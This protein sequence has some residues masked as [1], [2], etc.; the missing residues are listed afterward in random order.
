MSIST[1][2]G[3]VGTYY[4]GLKGWE[5]SVEGYWKR[6]NNVLEYKDGKM[7][8]SSASNWEENV[9]MG[10]GRSY[11]MEVYVQKTFGRTTGTASYTL[12]KSE[13]IF[14]DGSINDGRWFPFV[15]DRRHN[16]C[17]SLNQ[18]MGKRIDLSAVWTYSSGNWMTV[19]TRQTVIMSPD[20]TTMDTVDYIESRNNYR[21][22][23]SHRLDFSRNEIH[24]L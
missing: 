9:G 7:S 4:T 11:G 14:K 21:L 3:S 22:P 17:I 19:P 24:Y 18:K 6:L 16:V 23:P 1:T 13:R 12:S 15:Y 8:F 2:P 10:Q 20:G 5:F